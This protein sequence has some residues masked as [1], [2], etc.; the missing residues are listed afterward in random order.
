LHSCRHHGSRTV[1]V[2][3]GL[4]AGLALARAEQRSVLGIQIQELTADLAKALGVAPS[5]TGVLVSRV[6]EG[7]PAAKAGL[8][9]GDI[10]VEYD[11]QAV[12]RP[13]EL[14]ER[15]AAT[16]IGTSVTLKVLRTG[17]ATTLSATTAGMEMTGPPAEGP[18]T[19]RFGLAL[20]PLTPEIAEH[21]RIAE[22]QGLIVHAVRKGSVADL[23]GLR[24]GDVITEVN[25]QP[26][27]N[28]EQLRSA[29]EQATSDKPAVLLVLRDGRPR[30]VTVRG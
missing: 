27:T 19:G 15:V 17:Q 3:A 1:A 29:L 20:M 28:V 30:Y 18:K 23:A 9:A 22:Q 11:G 12:G 13:H 16:A 14:S 2:A 7:S 26:L 24:R 8:K 10:I 5:T 21:L 4:A 6:L 25:R